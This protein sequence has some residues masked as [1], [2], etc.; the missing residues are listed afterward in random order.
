[1]VEVQSLPD[2]LP[3]GAWLLTRVTHELRPQAG[4]STV[5]EG[6]IA[7]P[8]VDLLGALLGAVGGLL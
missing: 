6:Q 5:I 8:S 3:A 2:G 7:A 1:V 4:G